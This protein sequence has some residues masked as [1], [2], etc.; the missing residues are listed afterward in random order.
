MAILLDLETLGF[1]SD[2]STTYFKGSQ[3]L[4]PQYFR[5]L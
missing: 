4:V 5:L 3:N 2:T 1:L